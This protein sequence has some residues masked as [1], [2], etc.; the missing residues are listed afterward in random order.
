MGRP[1]K[2]KPAYLNNL[3]NS[4]W[5]RSMHLGNDKDLD[6]AIALLTEAVQLTP[7]EHS[8]KPSRLGNLGNTLC[9]RFEQR[10]KLAD[11]K[12]DKYAWLCNLG[13]SLCTRYSVLGELTDL[14]AAIERQTEAALLVPDGDADK[15]G[16]LSNLGVSHGSRFVRLGELA[17]LDAEIMFKAEAVKLTPGGDPD[18]PAYL[19]NFGNSLRSRFERLGGLEDLQKGIDVQTEAVHLTPEGHPDKPTWL[20]NLGILYWR[21]FE[22]ISKLTDIDMA[23]QLQTEAVQLTPAQHRDI[24]GR[25]NNLGNSLRARFMRLG[26]LT[27]LD[28]AIK[29][30]SQAVLLTPDGHTNKPGYLS[31]LGASRST[32]YDRLGELADLNAAIARHTAA[33]QLTPD[34]HPEKPGRLGNL[35]NYLASRFLLTE[36]LED[37]NIAIEHQSEAVFLT[38]DGDL[39]R[40]GRLSHLGYSLYT[41]F[42]R[43]GKLADLN[44]AIE[45][46]TKAELLTPDG[47]QDK[48]ERLYNL[49]RSLWGRFKRLGDLNEAVESLQC[50]KRAAISIEGSPSIRMSAC[51]DWARISHQRHLPDCLEAYGRVLEL[52]PRVAWLGYTVQRRYEHL[53]SLLATPMEAAAAAIEHNRLDLALEWLEESRAVVWT[54]MLRLRTPVDDLRLVNSK[55]ADELEQVARGLDSAGSLKVTPEVRTESQLSLERTAREHRRLALKW[56]ELI[57]QI[58]QIPKFERFLLP[59][60]A[61][62][63]A[64]SAHAST[65]VVINVHKSRC[66]ALALRLGSS[67]LIHIPLLTF[68]YDR[69]MNMLSQL[70]AAIQGSNTR[71]LESRRPVYSTSGAEDTLEAV[72]ATPWTDVVRPILDALGYLCLTKNEL[73]RVTWC[74]TG[75]LALLPLHAAGWYNEPCERA[76]DYVI[77]SYTPTLGPLLKASSISPE[78]HNILAVG[79]AIQTGYAPLPG[80]TTEL[81]KIEQQTGGFGFT[82]LIEE[83]ATPAAVIAAMRQHGWVH[84]ACHAS[85]NISDPTASAFQPHGGQL[86]LATITSEPLPNAELAFLSVCETATGMDMLPD[87][88]AHLAAGML[89]SGYRTV[90]ATMWSIKDIDA[91]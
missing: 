37:L 85:Q 41:R 78:F 86:S 64:S 43:L 77:S 3:G 75:L 47:H 30:Q 19:S 42:E 73:P 76:F 84:L 65:V 52:V 40:P 15:P 34:G 2:D 88:A 63:L 59:K 33:I 81:D 17:D 82:R 89:M 26:E 38:P 8:D 72:L 18:K 87:E 28:A 55:L 6:A 68:S 27:D 69:C 56:E 36:K 57:D 29:R 21:R 5:T 24:L 10:G 20:N 39:N 61:S 22:R 31:N 66:D 45:N 7:N 51:A 12:A 62:E 53:A 35:G 79:Q 16:L 9:T 49:G 67:D 71:T 50:L 32:R 48:P 74:T 25:L 46:Q 13:T 60:K 1:S 58:R 54:Q 14:D 4:L 70:L 80:T 91:P 83:N 23:I 44:S 90:I 11:L